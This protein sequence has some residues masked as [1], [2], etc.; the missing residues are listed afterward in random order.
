M[1]APNDQTLDR[2]FGK[3]LLG[4]LL[5][6][7][8]Q[9]VAMSCASATAAPSIRFEKIDSVSTRELW[10]LTLVGPFHA[11]SG[12]VIGFWA[13][14][15]ENAPRNQDWTA[16]GVA[17]AGLGDIGETPVAFRV[18]ARDKSGLLDALSKEATSGGAVAYAI[19]GKSDDQCVERERDL[20]AKILPSIAVDGAGNVSIDGKVVSAVK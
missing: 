7:A 16:I 11:K 9:G 15:P 14:D 2:V 5:L 4:L 8:H 6:I 13:Y 10:S 3:T 1:S 20:C 17:L 19:F 18:W 12:A